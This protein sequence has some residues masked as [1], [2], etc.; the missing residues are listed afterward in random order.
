MMLDYN[1][2]ESNGF[3]VLMNNYTCLKKCLMKVG[4]VFTISQQHKAFTLYKV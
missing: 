4:V 3:L 2:T 1:S